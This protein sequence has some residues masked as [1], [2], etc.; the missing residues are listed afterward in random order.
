[1]NDDYEA[2]RNATG[3]TGSYELLDAKAAWEK[4]GQGDFV[5]CLTHAMGG[6]FEHKIRIVIHLFTTYLFA[7]KQKKAPVV[8]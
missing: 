4:N 2:F 3:M 7:R 8:S 6:R 5:N 1:M